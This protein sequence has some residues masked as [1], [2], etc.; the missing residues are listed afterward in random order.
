MRP[1]GRLADLDPAS[2]YAELARRGIRWKPVKGGARGVLAP[3]RLD[4]PLGGVSF[5]TELPE[6]KRASSPWEVM[7]CRLALALHGWSA[8]LLAH[9]IDEV[10][11][12]SAWRPPAKSWP[13]GRAADRHPG[14]LALDVRRLRQHGSW[15]VVESDFH[16]KIGHRVCG[17]DADP[18]TE[19][20]PAAHELRALVCETAETGIFNTILTPDHD[21]PH[22][23]HLHVDIQPRASWRMVE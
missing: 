17:P 7:D 14:G 6:S 8:T 21:R 1:A 5:H 23:N 9:G 10:T 16:G 18:P 2:C 13:A 12:F 20:V 4:G 19:D 3:I 15:I 11:T 22:E